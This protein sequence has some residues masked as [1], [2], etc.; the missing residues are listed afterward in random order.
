LICKGFAWS[1]SALVRRS[2]TLQHIPVMDAL[3]TP[4]PPARCNRG[5]SRDFCP[6]RCIDS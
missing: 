4:E 6:W 1:A 3:W 2:W 5:I